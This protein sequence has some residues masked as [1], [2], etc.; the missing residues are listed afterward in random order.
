MTLILNNIFAGRRCWTHKNEDQGIV[1][2]FIVFGVPQA[3][4]LCVAR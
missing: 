1:D 2:D 3:R 4:Q